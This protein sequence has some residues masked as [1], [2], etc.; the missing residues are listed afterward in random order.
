MRAKVNGTELFYDTVGSQLVPVGGQMVERPVCFVLHGGPLIDLGYL[1]PW[2]DDLADVMQLVYVDYRGTGRSERMAPEHYTLENTID[3][4]EAL[5]VHLGLEKIAVLGHSHG[6]ILAMPFT[7]KYPRSVSHLILVA[8]TPY[9]GPELEAESEANQAAVAAANPE[10]ASL[11]SQLNQRKLQ[12]PKSDEEHRARF[13]R[14]FRLYFHKHDPQIIHD[15]AERTIFSTE[16]LRYWIEHE[17]H[18]YDVR[19]RLHEINAPTLILAARHDWRTTIKHARIM[20]Q[21]ISGSE[22]VIFEES[23]HQLYIEEQEKFL[24]TVRGFIQRNPI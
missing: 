7:L 24:S 10:L 14:T 20:N 6:G 22:L 15:V 16:K 13:H 8:T 5:R 3:D 9:T 11:M 18:K 12:E 23:G 4:L 17:S 2:M 21:G 1:R 19:P